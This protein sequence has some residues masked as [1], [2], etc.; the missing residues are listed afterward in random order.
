MPGNQAER[1][2][3]PVWQGWSTPAFFPGRG[4]Y[5][6]LVTAPKPA[7]Q[8]FTSKAHSGSDGPFSF[9]MSEGG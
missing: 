9:S 1:G 3:R 7:A 5:T 4:D 6:H 2:K 8:V